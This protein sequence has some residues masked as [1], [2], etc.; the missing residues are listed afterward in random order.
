[1]GFGSNFAESVL[2]KVNNN[3]NKEEEDWDA[4]LKSDCE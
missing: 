3:A 2:N 1:M 4:P